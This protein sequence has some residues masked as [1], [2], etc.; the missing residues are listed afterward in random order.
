MTDPKKSTARGGESDPELEL[1]AFS[2]PLEDDEA[3]EEVPDR[4]LVHRA[5]VGSAIAVNELWRRHSAFGL[6]AASAEALELA[7]EINEQAWALIV[8]DLQVS[9]GPK[10]AFRSYLY[11]TVHQL[12]TEPVSSPA[13]N[14]MVDALDTLPVRWQEIFWYSEVEK[15]SAPDLGRF[16]GLSEFEV[17][18][19]QSRARRALT[20]AWYRVNIDRVDTASPCRPI[21]EQLRDHLRKALTATES[22][23][24]N[25]HLASCMSDCAEVAS[26]SAALATQ[27]PALL[28]SALAGPAAAAALTTHFS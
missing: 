4:R 10:A 28:L 26:I 13:A 8:D 6:I 11:S 5:R 9:E 27:A 21:R 12:I 7:E 2:L 24:I 14:A 23:L 19:A 15:M 18:S 20:N 22:R 25:D 1:P 17:A 16:V 3:I